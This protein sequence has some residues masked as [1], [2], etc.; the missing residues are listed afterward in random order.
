SEILK[1]GQVFRT[2]QI[3]AFR[4]TVDFEMVLAELLAA[5]AYSDD[6]QGGRDQR[7]RSRV[8]V[9]LS[10]PSPVSHICNGTE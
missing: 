3:A 10:S 9:L 6:A 7:P 4:A 1:L 5:L 8:P 2:V